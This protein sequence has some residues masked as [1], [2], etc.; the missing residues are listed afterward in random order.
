MNVRL[1][2]SKETIEKLKADNVPSHLAGSLIMI[3]M[4][5]KHDNYNFLKGLD[6]NSKEKQVMLLYQLLLRKD[7]IEETK[8]E[9]MEEALYKLTMKGKNF[10]QLAESTDFVVDTKDEEDVE[11]W[12]DEY[13]NLF[14]EMVKGQRNLRGDRNA[15]VIRL[16]WFLKN[17]KNFDKQHILAATEEYIDSQAASS[18]GHKFTTT[19]DYF[20][21]KGQG[22]DMVSKLA[23][24][25]ETYDPNNLTPKQDLSRDTL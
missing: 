25:C 23:S 16:K 4:A 5:L 8:G 19:S 22:T 24:A 1:D 11:S 21:K 13:I 2:I 17:Y 18:E 9:E 6:D 12:V 10:I 7:Y 20:I 15:C 14:P 3:M